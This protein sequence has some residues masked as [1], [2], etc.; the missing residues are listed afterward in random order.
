MLSINS[1]FGIAFKITFWATS[2]DPFHYF[3]VTL[4]FLTQI[5][6]AVW[7]FTLFMRSDS[8]WLLAVSENQI[9]PSEDQDLPSVRILTTVSQTLYLI[10]LSN[11]RNVC[12]VASLLKSVGDHFEEQCSFD[13]LISVTSVDKL[14]WK[15]HSHTLDT[16][17]Y[18]NTLKSIFIFPR[19]LWLFIHTLALSIW[20]KHCN[21]KQQ[22]WYLQ[23]FWWT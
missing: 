3:R 1:C 10:P 16:L 4:H 2:D 13:C 21:E 19:P 6:L 11:S 5:L 9:F 12:I 15:A 20:P 22:K 7:S 8:E 18:H 23:P 17:L 14:V